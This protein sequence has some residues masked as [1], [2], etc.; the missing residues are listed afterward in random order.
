MSRVDTIHAERLK[1]IKYLILETARKANAGHIPSS[2]SCTEILYVLYNKIADI[3]KENAKNLQRDRVIISKEHA[4]LA[5]VCVLSEAGLLDEKYLNKYMVDGGVL[6]HDLY[7]RGSNADINV[8]DVSCGSLG[9][10]L[11]VGIGMALGSKNHNIYVIVGDG[12]CQEGSVW[13]G[14]M[15]AGYHKMNNLTLIVDNNNLQVD[16]FTKNIIDTSS[17]IGKQIESF[18]FDVFKCDG[19]NVDEL[20]KVFKIKTDRAKCIV[21]NTIKGKETLF[22]RKSR[23]LNVSHYTSLTPEEMRFAIEEVKK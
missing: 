6:G 4:R 17:N 19:H 22:L 12:E 13:E 21:A 15:F 23:G 2:L 18:G 14:I 10:G 3:T 1:Q 9:H 16:D 8:I 20:E 7:G 5:Q 11:S